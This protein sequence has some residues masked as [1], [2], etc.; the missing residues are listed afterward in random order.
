MTANVAGRV[1]IPPVKETR[2]SRENRASVFITTLTELWNDD[3]ERQTDRLR[4]QHRA[5]T[6]R[7]MHAFWAEIDHSMQPSELSLPNKPVEQEPMTLPS[8]D[9]IAAFSVSRPPN[10]QE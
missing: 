1:A 3:R 4:I 9:N 6:E 5:Q 8:G 10:L 7:F 2:M